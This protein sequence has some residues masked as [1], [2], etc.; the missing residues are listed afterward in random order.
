[1]AYTINRTNGL[2]PIV[3]PD[4]TI[5]TSTSVQLVGKNYPNYG[6]ILDQNFLKLLE[7]SASSIA[8][9][10]P[11]T[12]ELW[13]DSGGNVLKVWSGTQW[14][15]V[16]STTSG[17]TAPSSAYS[18]VGD[19]WWKTG[20]NQLYGFDGASYKLIGP[21]GG[22]SGIISEAITD[23]DDVDRSVL[24]LTIGESR[25]LIL[26][27]SPTFT[28]K[29][30]ISGF[31][32][33]YP[34][35]NL[36]NTSFLTNAKFY[37]QAND[38]V[39]LTGL[40]AN[41]FLR[42]DQNT[43][44]PFTLSVLNN[45]GFTVGTGSQLKLSVSAPNVAIANDSSSGAMN[46]R[47]RNSA[48]TQ[49]NAMDIYPNGNVVANF[50]F[51]VQ[52]NISFGNSSND[53]KVTGL[54]QSTNTSTG[55]LQVT[56]GGLGV[57]GNINTGGSLNNFTGNVRAG[58]VIAVTSVAA[59]NVWATANVYGTLGSPIQ[60][61][62][63]TLG[64]LNSLTVAGAV[65]A[66]SV[67]G[68]VTQNAQPYITSVG[69]LSSLTVSGTS[70]LGSNTSVKLSGGLEGQTLVSDGTSNLKWDYPFNSI[71]STV[72][73][74]AYFN[75]SGNLATTSSMQY[76]SVTGNVWMNGTLNVTG[77]IIA[78]ATSDL[79]LKENLSPIEHALDKVGAL[80]GVSYNWNEIAKTTLDKNDN[81]EIGIVAQELQQVLPEAVVTRDNGYLAVNY[82]RI[83]PL[84]IEAIKD[85]RHEVM[86]LK[87]KIN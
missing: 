21:I 48:G 59:N 8:P 87:K 70:T 47:V 75:G 58:N 86:E 23:S 77:D 68:Y 67:S 31:A 12:G 85:L 25:Y 78:F 5:N 36:S 81:R 51:L 80:N 71:F 17:A 56:Q 42:A 24:S 76:N 11:I 6:A 44:T 7:N 64:T 45:T 72:N 33:I 39:T 15:N 53:L 10:A 3:I 13:W 38:S 28:P 4:G 82:E 29:T 35:L 16:G 43:S 69:T 73:S 54:S 50:D 57:F 40:Y 19:L 27:N 41:A 18:N 34:G 9:S 22:A 61:Y 74:I 46:F 30:A 55:A 60:P 1:M 26:S 14:K 65:S 83:V 63:S 20:D 49:I 62:I 79:R 2:N 32:K 66:V 37:G 52:G 84:L